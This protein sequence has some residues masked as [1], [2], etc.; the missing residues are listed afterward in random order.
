M[1]LLVAGLIL[2]VLGAV[3][4]GMQRAE[5]EPGDGPGLRSPAR[6]RPTR[7]PIAPHPAAAAPP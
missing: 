4:P 2:P 1:H 3:G 6:P 5:R 7:R